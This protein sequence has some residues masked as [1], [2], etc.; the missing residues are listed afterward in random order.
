MN[1][2]LNWKKGAFSC[3]YQLLSQGK[4]VG[5]LKD[6]SLKQKAIG[7]LDGKKYEFRTTGMLTSKTDIIDL[8][9]GKQVGKISFNC[10]SPEAKIQVGDQISHWGFTNIWQS[11]WGVFS[12][13]KHPLNFQ[14]NSFKGSVE[15]EEHAEVKVLAGLFISNYFWSM[16]AVYTSFLAFI[17]IFWM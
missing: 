8:E 14:G 5:N 9:S 1:T 4:K 7:E 10:W 6:F 13:G 2:V 15:V 17:P 3:N 16:A 11:K 12:E